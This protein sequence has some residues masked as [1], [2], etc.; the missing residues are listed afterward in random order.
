[1]MS[2]LP[3]LG[4]AILIGYRGP[5]R[6]RA[7]QRLV[8]TSREQAQIDDPTLGDDLAKVLR[9]IPEPPR[10]ETVPSSPELLG[11][12]EEWCEPAPVV[13]RRRDPD[14]LKKRLHY[15]RDSTSGV[16]PK[17]EYEEQ[18]ESFQQRAI[19]EG[20]EQTRANVARLRARKS[21][22]GESRD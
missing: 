18:V 12:P 8:G 3:R 5:Y 13:E 21:R 11:D 17:T 19:R 6:G 16:R 7:R 15:F 14:V 10:V 2:D 9:G 1:M 4:F 20:L 22:R